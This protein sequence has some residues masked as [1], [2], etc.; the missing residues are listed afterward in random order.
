MERTITAA[1]HLTKPDN[2]IIIKPA[3]SVNPPTPRIKNLIKNTRIIQRKLSTLTQSSGVGNPG[4]MEG[5]SAR[6][7]LV[8]DIHTLQKQSF[9]RLEDHGWTAGDLPIRSRRAYQWLTF[10]TMDDHFATHWRTLHTLWSLRRKIRTPLRY[11]ST[12]PH[13]EL[14]HI[15]ALYRI[16]KSGRDL[17]ISIQESY[18]GAPE[19]VLL[20]IWQLA[21]QT[22]TQQSRQILQDYARTDRYR[23][24]RETMEYLD[25]PAGSFSTGRSRD[26]AEVFDRV[27]RRYF[28]G[29]LHRPHL[30][31][32]RRSTFRKFGHYQYDTDTI[33]IS[34]SLDTD[35]VPDYVL[36]YL[37]FHELLHKE[38][39]LRQIGTRS[40]AH[41]PAFRKAEEQFPRLAN[42]RR[43]LES[44]SQK[45]KNS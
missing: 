40:Y 17:K 5:Q 7:Q 23:L 16:K 9:H 44:Y 21:Y 45:I 30:K 34:C 18:L 6:N 43:F 39:G 13:L 41:T 20:A 26:L 15:S 32:S 33:L 31:W 29:T 11:K 12:R 8:E 19:P 38:H 10:L 1:A 28:S 4:L 27:N 35:Q 42:A 3:M 37:M 22:N 25:V 24:S 36:D 14:M 2:L